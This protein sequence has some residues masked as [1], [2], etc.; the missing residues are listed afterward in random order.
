MEKMKILLACEIFPPDIGGPATYAEKFAVALKDN[1]HDVVILCYS[2]KRRGLKYIFPVRRILRSHIKIFHYIKYFLTLLFIAKKLGVIYSQG[3]VSSG[4]PAIIAGKILRKNVVVKVVGD[5]AWEQA[6]SFNNIKNLPITQIPSIDDFQLIHPKGRIGI[7]KKIQV[8]VCKRVNKVIVPSEY[9]R[10][11]VIGWGVDK[12]KV[13]VIYNSFDLS[14]NY[15]AELRESARNKLKFREEDFIILSIGRAVAWKGFGI[16]TIAVAHLIQKYN[17]IK[18][19]ILGVNNVDEIIRLIRPY[20]DKVVCEVHPIKGDENKLA[21]IIRIE[22][23]HIED[24]T[25]GIQPKEK[26]YEYL[27]SA[28][29]FVL[30]SWYEGL[31]HSILEAF[32][33]GV[34]VIASSVGGNPELIKNGEN[35]LLVEYNSQGQI[36][37]AILKLYKNPE[38]RKYF[39]KNSKEILKRFDFQTMIEKTINVLQI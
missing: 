20:N 37:E 36:E 8:F 5:Y 35:G 32:A 29:L 10:N 7:L 2:D 13:N 27:L 9:L 11:I 39:I 38:L 30:N 18:L 31:S 16:L 6:T 21:R 26:V 1:H 17:N 34:P 19:R 12:S 3:P 33:F 4:L 23:N 22:D 28:D 15:G 24:P 25:L 14:K